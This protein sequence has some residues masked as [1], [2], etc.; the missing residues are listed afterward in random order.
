MSIHLLRELDKLKRDLL[1]LCSIVEE[2]VHKAIRSL[3]DHDAELA[4]E[5][6]AMDDD[7]DRREISLD[8]DCLKTLALYQPVAINLRQLVAALK[9]NNDLERIGDMAVNI[10]RKSAVLAAETAVEIPTDFAEMGERTQAMLRKSLDS[11][12]QLDVAMARD[13]CASDDEIDLLKKK[14]RN[15]IEQQIRQ[16]PQRVG[17]MLRLLSVSRNLER[18]ADSAVDIAEDVIYMVD[19][20]IVRHQTD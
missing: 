20:R 7:V 16:N 18:I 8:E 11:L 10:A 19:G 15:Q 1:L 6:Q 13:V 9:I 12:V 17:S 14:I 2:Q 5:V 4:Q 3:L